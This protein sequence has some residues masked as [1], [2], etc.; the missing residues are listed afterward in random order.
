MYSAPEPGS[1]DSDLLKMLELKENGQDPG[2][3]ID[4]AIWKLLE[5]M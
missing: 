1:G 2:K 4:N 5:K 3:V